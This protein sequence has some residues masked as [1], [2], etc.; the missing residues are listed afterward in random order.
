MSF[1]ESLFCCSEE[2]RHPVRLTR[3]K[4]EI[5]KEDIETGFKRN[6]IGTYTYDNGDQYDGEWMD[7]KRHGRG[8]MIYKNGDFFLGEWITDKK[9]GRGLY[10]FTNMDKYEG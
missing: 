3:G 8:K 5:I 10:V 4:N 2:E 9:G 6:G 1:L 7:H